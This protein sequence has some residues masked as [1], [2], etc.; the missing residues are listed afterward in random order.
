MDQDQL[1]LAEFQELAGRGR[2]ELESGAPETASRSL[3]TALG[4]WRGAALADL[5]E[6][7]IRWPEITA[8]QDMR[9]DVMEDFFEAELECGRA[10]SILTEMQIAV[11]S[12][13]HRERLCEQLMLA[14]YRCGRQADALSVYRAFGR[15][16]RADLGLEPSRRLREFEHLVLVHN[17]A[18]VPA[19][20]PSP[21]LRETA[22]IAPASAATAAPDRPAADRPVPP[23]APPP[24]GREPSP[25]VIRTGGVLLL[26]RH[27][28]PAPGPGA[29]GGTASPGA[30]PGVAAVLE[31]EASRHGVRLTPA[32]GHSW[33]AVLGGGQELFGGDALRAV[34]TAVAI[35]R[36][37]AR[38]SSLRAAVVGPG[39]EARYRLPGDPA[40][41]RYWAL[42]A[43]IPPGEVRVCDNIRR[44]TEHDVPYFREDPSPVGWK[45]QAPAPAPAPA[46]ADPAGRGSARHIFDRGCELDVLTDML[47]LV[48]H[49][50]RPDL[51]TILGEPGIGKSSLVSE[52]ERRTRTDPNTAHLP[53]VRVAASGDGVRA[54]L[55]ETVLRYCGIE[56]PAGHTADNDGIPDERLWAGVRPAAETDDE[57]RWMFAGLRVL[58]DPPGRSGTRSWRDALPF[59]RRFLTRSA[60]GRPLVLIVE[61][62][63]RADGEALEFVNTLSRTPGPLPLLLV[64][65]ARPE[66][67][68]QRPGWGTDSRHAVTLTLEPLSD[69]AV[70]RFLEVL[71][72][73]HG[74]FFNLLTMNS[75]QQ[76]LAV[77][78][79]EQLLGH[80]GGNP[81]FAVE[82]ARMLMDS[83]P[84]GPGDP[85]HRPTPLPG[86]PG[87]IV[88]APL[89]PKV[90]EVI[91]GQLRWITGEARITLRDAAV[92][93]DASEPAAVAA[94]GRRDTGR[95]ARDLEQLERLGILVNRFD[96]PA[97]GCRRYAFRH[98]LV[99][100]TVYTEIPEAA[101]AVKH[102]RA[103]AWLEEHRGDRIEAIAQH[104][105]RSA[106]LAGD[107]AG[108]VMDQARDY[109]IG[110][111]RTADTVDT[112][113]KTARHYLAAVESHTNWFP[114]RLDL[115]IHDWRELL[116]KTLGPGLPPAP[117]RGELVPAGSPAYSPLLTRGEGQALSGW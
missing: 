44:A 108:T 75:E 4:L 43:G 3:R 14:L 48:C 72:G 105:G 49:R 65:S 74:I 83:V 73:R 111:S 113:S 115:L 94:L 82:Y 81:M 110:A 25:S 62:L 6:K 21:A 22:T 1:D 10:G 78:F 87:D 106:G 34:R 47:K 37:A 92:L 52:F 26:L 11:E 64:T 77:N 91:A 63:D 33:L 19:D 9:L 53:V 17:E 23:A 5:V 76:R 40:L 50:T 79:C 7:D 30:E 100:H 116:R 104:R 107:S 39:H 102:R 38:S 55:R 97:E 24:G 35:L 68:R 80:I 70:N 12:H 88:S 93:G 61:D 71:F 58:L 28:A 69:S 95:V 8:L 46:A 13:P 54:A 86:G 41:D 89:L 90:F 117:E 96:R 85:A 18:L 27:A 112:L 84:L 103:A 114:A 59:W 2:G 109:L 36:R 51:V 66:L 20:A 67:L 16:L 45:V 57:A 15:R 98:R 29:P 42:L 60:A 99:R 31:Q 32:P 101:L 56:Q